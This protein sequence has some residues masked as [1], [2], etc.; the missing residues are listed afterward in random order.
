MIWPPKIA[1]CVGTVVLH[2]QKVLLIREAMGNEAG[3]W[4]IPWGFVE[5]RSADGALDTPEIAAIRE[6]HEEAG[7]DA[8][9]V[10][11]LGIQNHASRSGEPRLYLIFLAEHVSGEPTPD[12]VETDRA[13][14]LSLA[15]INDWP[16]PIDD[17]VRWVVIR[18]LT[19]QSTMLEPQPI[20]PYSPL[21][22][23]F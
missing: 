17:F 14:Y 4:G 7:V 23:F 1:L 3:V 10:G 16:E 5:G 11:L 22:G 19:G 2:E 9:I 12:G 15:E 6:T 21:I 13:A 18:V 20:N 8:K